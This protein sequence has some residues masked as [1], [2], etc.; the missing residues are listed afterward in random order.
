M[1]IKLSKDNRPTKPGL[2]VM[3]EHSYSVPIIVEARFILIAGDEFPSE[4][5]EVVSLGFGK[6]LN[7]HKAD[8]SG[9][10]QHSVSL[11]AKFSEPLS[12]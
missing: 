9:K 1:N 2:Y 5:L 12:F 3:Q 7:E 8:G 11:E 10:W 4:D 6:V